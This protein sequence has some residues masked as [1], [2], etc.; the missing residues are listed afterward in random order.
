MF[1]NLLRAFTIDGCQTNT[2]VVSS[3]LKFKFY[4]VGTYAH[5]NCFQKTIAIYASGRILLK[6]SSYIPVRLNLYFLIFEKHII[7]WLLKIP[8]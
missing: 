5:S 8:T 3:I 4:K 7:H 1:T 6:L 2:V